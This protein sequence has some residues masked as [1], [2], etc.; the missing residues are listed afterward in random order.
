MQGTPNKEERL[1]RF[2]ISGTGL[3]T[4]MPLIVYLSTWA[5][6]LNDEISD[7]IYVLHIILL[8]LYILDN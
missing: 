1:E 8:K 5:M 7:E 6:V 4:L 2:H 3:I